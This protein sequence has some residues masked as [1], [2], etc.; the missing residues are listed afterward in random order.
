MLDDKKFN[1]YLDA[2]KWICDEILYR[3][4]SNEMLLNN[5]LRSTLKINWMILTSTNFNQAL[6][7]EE[8]FVFLKLII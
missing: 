3:M 4:N 7:H 2:G 8:V 1:W 5:L 6:F